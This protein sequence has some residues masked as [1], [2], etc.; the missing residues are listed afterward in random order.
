MSND[1][2]SEWYN[3]LPRVTRVIGTCWFL[4]AAA[5]SFQLVSPVIMY[6]NWD[7]VFGK[8]VQGMQTTQV[9]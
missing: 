9:R 3:Q 5:V 7:L 4:S 2:F 6:M 8:G 1:N